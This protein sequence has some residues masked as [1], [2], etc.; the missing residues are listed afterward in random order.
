M[1]PHAMLTLEPLGSGFPQPPGWADWATTQV[2][3]SSDDLTFL[4]AYLHI[5]ITHI[6]FTM[7]IANMS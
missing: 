1:H 5:H 2:W 6:S 3:A 4:D 7:Q